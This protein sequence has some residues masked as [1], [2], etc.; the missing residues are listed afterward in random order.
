MQFAS[1][2]IRNVNVTRIK[3]TH[4]RLWYLLFKRKVGV[5]HHSVAA[6]E[7][8]K[9]MVH[10]DK[11]LDDGLDQLPLL[12]NLVFFF[13]FLKKKKKKEKKKKKKKKR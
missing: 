5:D 4:S 10:L 8:D 12:L 6:V 13:F 9:H 11:A 7:R 3:M 2:L 1:Y